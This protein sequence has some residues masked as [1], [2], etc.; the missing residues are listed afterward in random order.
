MASEFEVKIKKI[1]STNF[2]NVYKTLERNNQSI[3]NVSNALRGS[4]YASIRTVLTKSAES[5][6][7]YIVSVK[8]M[9]NVLDLIAQ[10]YEVTENEILEK[11]I[12]LTKDTESTSWFAKFVGNDLKTSGSVLSGEAKTEGDLWGIGTA[13]TASGAL[14]TGEA[15][16]KSNASWSFKD[17]DGNWD[18]KSFGLSTTA[19]ATGAVAKGEVKGNVGYLHGNASGKFITGAI[20]GDAKMK[21]WDDGQWNPSLMI[22]AKAGVSVLQGEA[23]VG[24]GT[25]QYGI[26]AKADGDVLHA[27]AEAGAGVGYIGK[28]ENGN[29]Q[30]GAKAKASAMACVAQGKVKGGVTIF[31]IDIDVGLK[32]Y[33]LAA[34]V[35]AGASIT[36]EGVTASF[37]GAA[38]LGAGLDISVD[39]SDAEWIEDGIDWIGDRAEDAGDAIGDFFAGAADVA[40]DIGDFIFR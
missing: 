27:E 26:Y 18:F 19:S 24:F 37:S 25:D 17:K 29:A 35:E 16:I 14:L 11:K 33:A 23:K 32:G 40:G 13:G 2:S 9:D 36:T 39:W 38:V 3:K 8:Q 4:S 22:G 20:S 31:G 15:G 1:K 5:N 34:G 6:A 12:E 30:Y 10:Q 7:K 28:D 21:L